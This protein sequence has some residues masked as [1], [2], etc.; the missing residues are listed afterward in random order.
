VREPDVFL[1]D[2]PLSNLDLE[3]RVETRAELKA[4]HARVGG[5]M[6]HVTHDQTEALVLGHRIAVM[7]DGQLEQVGTP[8]EIWRRPATTFVARFV[9]SPAMNLVPADGAIRPIGLPSDVELSTG[10]QF[11]FRPEAVV[12]GHADGDPGVVVRIDVIGEDAYAYIRVAELHIVARM[13]AAARPSP[14]DAVTVSVWW[15]DTHLFEA[16]GQRW[17]AR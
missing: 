17:A 15:W 14:G 4:L 11:G 10:R 16:T 7:R 5:S 6:V 3:T 8:E 2:E 13:S 9:G 12:L 1:L